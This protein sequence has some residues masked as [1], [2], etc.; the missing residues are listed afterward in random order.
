MPLVAAEPAA[1]ALWSVLNRAGMN[2]WRDAVDLR[3]VNEVQT[4]G[5]DIPADISE[6]P[7]V[8]GELDQWPDLPGGSAIVDTDG[9]GMP[10]DYENGISYLNPNNAADRNLDINGNGYTDLEDYLNF[11]AT[12]LIPLAGDYNDDGTVDAIDYTVWRDLLGTAGSLQ[13]ETASLGV[14]DGADYDAW[15]A[16]FGATGG[17]GNG[18]VVNSAVPEPATAELMMIVLLLLSRRRIA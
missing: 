6:V 10:N 4:Q 15:K 18:S 12:P 11:L 14:I 7:V 3:I 17:S 5:G 1:D 8:A 9:D 2:L 13:N 16:N